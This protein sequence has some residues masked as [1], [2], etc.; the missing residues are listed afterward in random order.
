MTCECSGVDRDAGGALEA[1]VVERRRDAT[2]EQRRAAA[3]RLTTRDERKRWARVHRALRARRGGRGARGRARRGRSRR[4]RSVPRAR[5]SS[6]STGRDRD[7]FRSR[8]SRDR[9][10]AGTQRSVKNPWGLR[11]TSRRSPGASPSRRGVSFPPATSVTRNSSGAPGGDAIE[12]ER[13]SS[14]AAPSTERLTNWPGE[15]GSTSA[16]T[17]SVESPGAQSR[18]DTRRPSDQPIMN[19]DNP[20]QPFEQG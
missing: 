18:R 1:A 5:G 16:S 20:P 8:P 3:S 9:A 6:A 11:S 2:V 12:Y 10:P 15:N 13:R 4:V 17:R 19:F 7:R 14:S